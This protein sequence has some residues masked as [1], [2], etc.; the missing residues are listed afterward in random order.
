MIMKNNVS[1]LFLLSILLCT[2]LNLGRGSSSCN[3]YGDSNVVESGGE[4]PDS[5]PVRT[6]YSRYGMPYSTHCL[7]D[8]DYNNKN[9]NPQYPNGI[10][11]DYIEE[12]FN[13]MPGTW[14]QTGSGS[15][16]VKPIKQCQSNC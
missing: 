4:C 8:P 16:T 15:A 7:S 14:T 1:A 13:C 3:C 6:T 10:E 5:S 9:C 12:T 11:L 2:A